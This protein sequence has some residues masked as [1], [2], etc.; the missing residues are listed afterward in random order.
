MAGVI[1]LH[2]AHVEEAQPCFTARAGKEILTKS[3]GTILE[4]HLDGCFHFLIPG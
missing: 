3:S 2:E 1:E 4:G